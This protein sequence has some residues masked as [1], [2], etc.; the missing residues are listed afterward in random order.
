MKIFKKLLVV[1]VSAISIMSCSV[2]ALAE[3]NWESR[4]GTTVDGSVLT[5][6]HESSGTPQRMARGHYLADGSSY[7]SDKGNNVVYISG[8]TS[9]YRTAD[10]L[11][12][13]VYLQRLV[14][15]D[16]ETVTYQYQTE[17]DTYYTH[18][19]FFITVTPGYYYRT[20]STHV[21][22]KGDVVE[23]MSTRTEGLYIG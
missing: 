6:E 22:I 4:L 20:L 13:D 18:N 3:E 5:S 23:S 7:I 2:T 17:Y 19:G 21:A 10:E 14:G 12:V 11:R 15:N 1:I 16:W 8:S 9:C